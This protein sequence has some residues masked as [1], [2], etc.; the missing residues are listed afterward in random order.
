VL[1]SSERGRGLQAARQLVLRAGRVVQVRVATLGDAAQRDALVE[2]AL[3]KSGARYL[4]LAGD[5]VLPGVNWL[6][7]AWQV[8][9]QSGKGFLALNCGQGVGEN[10]PFAMLRTDWAKQQHAVVG[11]TSRARP[12]WHELESVAQQQDQWL[13]HADAVV[14]NLDPV[15]QYLE[16]VL[17]ASAP[18]RA[19]QTGFW[20][21]L[22]PWRRTQPQGQ[23]AALDEP[24]AA[25]EGIEVLEAGQ[26]PGPAAANPDG[27][28]VIM[29]AIHRRRALAT[30]RMLR[31]R[32]GIDVQILVVIDT[33]RQGFVKTLN[34][35]A[36]RVKSRYLVYLAEDAVAGQ[37]WLKRAWDA[38]EESGKGLLAF[39]CGKWRGRIAAFGMVRSEWIG[40]VYAKDILFSG[41]RAHRADNELTAIARATDEFVYCAE[42]LLMENDPGK[43]VL[44]QGVEQ[45]T[46]ADRRLFRQRYAKGFDG[47][48][49]AERLQEMAGEYLPVH[50]V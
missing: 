23:R 15:E 47:R 43:M 25:D 35:T 48:A 1:G 14:F 34:R 36:R 17:P 40:R 2:R 37:D 38:L 8:L 5:R 13:Q 4:V 21:R 33:R 9:E 26:S 31:D 29:P 46:K 16:A 24:K 39:N 10:A 45:S 30:A 50:Q 20:Q 11:A 44:D 42:A 3:A 28:T 18:S 27:V 22:L 12:L 7:L 49:P 41:Y 6:E 32:A 19:Q